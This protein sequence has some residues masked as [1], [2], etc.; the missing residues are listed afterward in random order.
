M[1]HVLVL[2]ALTTVAVSRSWSAE[3]AEQPPP[4]WQKL[5]TMSETC[6][7]AEGT[8]EDPNAWIWE[9]E[10]LATGEKF[11]GKRHA[12]WVAFA[13]P[14]T[15]VRPEDTKAGSRTFALF[16]DQ[17]QSLSITYKLAGTVVAT[18]SFLK[19]AWSCTPAGIVVTTIDREGA[20]LDKLPNKGR[21]IERAIV[22]VKEGSLYV[23]TIR[24]TKALVLGVL[25]QSFTHV[26]WQKFHLAK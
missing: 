6:R 15:A 12:A 24:E 11:N 2:V 20:V 25:P 3:L 16:I 4:E 22:R 8:Y 10:N 7:E 17:T 21:A 19:D 26:S 1:H 13:L 14:A 18:R 5:P 23:H 9:R